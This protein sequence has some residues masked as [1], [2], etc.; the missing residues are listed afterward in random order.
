[1][2]MNFIKQELKAVQSYKP[3]KWY[4]LEMMLAANDIGKKNG[5]LKAWLDNELIIQVDQMR[6]RDTDQLKMW[7][8]Y[9]SC[10]FGGGGM[11]NTSPKDQFIFIDD[12]VISGARIGCGSS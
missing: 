12:Y 5:Q 2:V 4:C 7:R 3:G 9:V 1:M 10:Y 6:F 8:F 11:R